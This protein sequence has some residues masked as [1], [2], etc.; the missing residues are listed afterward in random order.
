MEIVIIALCV[1]LALLGLVFSVLPP[2]P[3]P[4]LPL[5]GLYMLHFWHPQ[6]YFSLRFLLIMSAITVIVL[7][8]ENIIPIWGTKKLGGSRAGIIGSTVGLFAGLFL[9]T[10]VTGPFS[11]IVGPFLGAMIGELITGKDMRIA[12]R[13]GLGS[14]AGF[15]AGTGLKLI[16]SAIMIWQMG[17]AVF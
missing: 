1:I 4:L 14:F 5:G 11:I 7:I 12:L 9:L 2:I 15:L 17:A 16:I 6:H 8:I 3:G 10:P 13:S